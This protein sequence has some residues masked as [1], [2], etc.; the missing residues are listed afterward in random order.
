[1]II[2]FILIYSKAINPTKEKTQAFNIFR[3]LIKY[4]VDY[5]FLCTEMKVTHNY[6][7][8]TI[9][10]GSPKTFF[11]FLGIKFPLLT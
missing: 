8:I 6:I 10:Q 11:S 2:T 1:M 3:S 9:V 7:L 5:G 4:L